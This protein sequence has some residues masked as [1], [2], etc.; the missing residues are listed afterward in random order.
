MKRVLILS[1]AFFILFQIKSFAQN[2][3]INATGSTPDNSAMLDI[4]S[5]SKG[6]LIPRMTQAE[7]DAI[8]S[9]ATGLM[10][11]QTDGTSGFYYY[12][13]IAWTAM[14]ANG[15]ETKL[16]AGTNVTVTGGVLNLNYF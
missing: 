11:F 1:V 12:N 10:I 14:A 7:R 9:P 8:A 16:T 15:S 3:G 5:T 4:S 13:G 2:V 6:L